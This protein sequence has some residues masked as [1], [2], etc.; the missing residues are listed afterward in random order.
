MTDSVEAPLSGAADF[1]ISNTVRRFRRNYLIR[2]PALA[3]PAYCLWCYVRSKVHEMCPVN[4]DEWK[5]RIQ[6]WVQDSRYPKEMKQVV[7]IF[8]SLLKECIERH[9]G[10]LQC[11]IQ[12]VKIN[13][14]PY[15]TAFPYG[16]GMVLHFYQQQESSTTKTVHKVINKGL[17]TYV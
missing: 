13:I 17:K 12:T 3:V 1:Q 8:S 6:V 15:P 11:H 10:H 9:G 5:Q 7:M 2:S 4:T 14:N 16:N